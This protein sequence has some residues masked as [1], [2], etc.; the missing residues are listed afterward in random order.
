VVLDG[1]IR[2][3]HAM[4]WIA[5]ALLLVV[6]GLGTLVLLGGQVSMTCACPVTAGGRPVMPSI[7]HGDTRRSRSGIELTQR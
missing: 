7:G 4:R 6:L 3:V 1:A 2:S 5:A